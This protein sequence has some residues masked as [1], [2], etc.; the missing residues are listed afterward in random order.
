M[1]SEMPDPKAFERF[2]KLV[3]KVIGVSKPELDKRA[4]EWRAAR[5]ADKSDESEE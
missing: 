5:D 1:E 3:K 4:E 2:R